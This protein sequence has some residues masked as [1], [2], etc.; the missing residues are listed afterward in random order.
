MN[1]FTNPNQLHVNYG[2]KI[3]GGLIVY[4]LIMKFAGLLNVVE[5][6][7]LNVIILVGGIYMALKKFQHTHGEH[8]NYFRA[9]VTGVATGAIASLVFA[10]F[11]FIYVTFIDVPFMQ[12]IIDNEPM[13]RF[14]NPYIVSFIVALEG[15]FSGLLVTFVLINYINTD[16]PNEG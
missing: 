3:A 1:V 10:A 4:F 12:Y 8:I 9:L 15:V 14:L 7:L 5:L 11:L 16:E 6:R 2:L 13:G